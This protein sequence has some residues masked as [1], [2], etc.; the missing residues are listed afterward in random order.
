MDFLKK[1]LNKVKGRMTKVELEKK[2]GEATVNE[3][4]L[5]SI[6]L[7]NEIASRTDDIEE[8]KIISKA[9]IKLLGV[10][11]K[12]WKRILRALAVIEHVLKTG[13]QNFVDQIKD[14]RDRIKDLFEFKYEEESKD[15]GEPSKFI[16]FLI[17]FFSKTKVTIYI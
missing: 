6:S 16:I 13:S 1:S 14:E 15:R 10:K 5:P 8:C 11:P 9:C 3:T 4:G 7:L 17:Y 12:F 2:I